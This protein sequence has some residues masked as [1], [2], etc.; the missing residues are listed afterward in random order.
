MSEASPAIALIGT[1]AVA[2]EIVETFGMACFVAAYCEPQYAQA[3]YVRLP[4]YTSLEQLRQV[5]SHYVIGLADPAHR[6]RLAS[7]AEEHGLIA[8]PPLVASTA[9]VSPSAIVGNGSVF[10]HGVQIGANAIVGEHNLFTY[11]A[12]F[13]HDSRSGQHVVLGPAVH[14]AGEVILGD[15]VTARANATLAKGITV[16]DHALIV[17]S[18]ACFRSIPPHATVIGNPARVVTRRELEGI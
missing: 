12:I 11:H 15:G 13:G 9:R 2:Q 6:I 17:Q 18:A 4:I 5:A 7:A 10:A 16:G 8:A 1:G 3:A 14:V